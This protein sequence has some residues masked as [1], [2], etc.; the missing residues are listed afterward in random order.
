MLTVVVPLSF[1]GV[2]FAL[3]QAF[4]AWG[5]RR[6]WLRAAILSGGY[7][8]LATEVLSLFA[9]VTQF[10]LV[11]VWGLLAAAVWAWALQRWAKSGFTRP[12]VQTS[13]RW[14]ERLMLLAICLAVLLGAVVAWFAPPSTWDSL[15][16][17]IPRVAE[18][19]QM[20][21]VRP[22]A[23]GIEVQNN[24]PPG[25]EEAVLNLY[26]LAG[27]DRVANFVDWFAFMGSLIGVSLIAGQLGG[28]RSAQMLS[29]LLAATLP[30]VLAQTSSTMTDLVSAFWLVCAVVE[31]L[32]FKRADFPLAEAVFAGLAGAMVVV[33]RPPTVPFVGVFG[34]WAGWVLLRRVG[35]KRAGAAALMAL[36]CVLTI[37]AGAFARTIEVYGSLVS[38][39]RLTVH[40]NGNRSPAGVTS[41]LVRYLALNVG[42][43]SPYLNKVAFLA[44][45][46][47]HDWMGVDK[48]DPRTTSTGE[49]RV[50]PPSTHED[51]A[52]NP[53]H[54]AIG[55]L[56]LVGIL[57][58]R[59][60]GW[61][62]L[63]AYSA[64][65][66]AGL[67]LFCWAFKWEIFGSRY[68]VPMFL[69]FAPVTAIG[70]DR[71]LPEKV[72][73]VTALVFATACWPWLTS[74]NSRPL[75]R[76]ADSFVGSVLTEPRRTLLFA[77]ALY[78]E[79]PLTTEAG[80]IH[81]A[82]CSTVGIALS[83]NAP[84]YLLWSV[85]G[86]PRQ[87][88][89]VEWIVGG[90]PSARFADPDFAP[91]AVVCDESCPADWTTIRGL[92]LAY[93]RA[94]YRLFLRTEP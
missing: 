87:D 84:E 19:A 26:V 54:F 78:L 46:A 45:S 93:E 72:V 73:W 57:W 30:S 59:P 50:R 74:I 80:L 53:L 9:A 28:S 69:V 70:L 29:A 63:A 62:Q 66:S 13:K 94:G 64:V 10:A 92:P 88:L 24:M 49:F 58:R 68:L 55:F 75:I 71:L 40:A 8:I 81:E 34:L 60:A 67:V 17:H 37:N 21:A 76:R 36:V 35:W 3:L 20:H 1:A 65:V 12:S 6:A 52:A 89:R 85:L 38:G 39:D 2:W 91:C 41:N 56:V 11:L 33:T 83:G 32:D 48:N 82:G 44:V 7:L 27:S 61:R 23:T 16:Y 86:A 18:W 5:W 25:A 90:T 43:P 4:P 22:F 47:V 14:F 79:D 15:N 51:L 31:V 77:N 42:T